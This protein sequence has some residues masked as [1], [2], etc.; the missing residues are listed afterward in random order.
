MSGSSSGGREGTVARKDKEI[1]YDKSVFGAPVQICEQCMNRERKRASRKKNKKPEEEE[2]WAQDERKR[3]IVFNTNQVRQFEQYPGAQRAIAAE[4]QMRICCYCRHH[5]EKD[6]FQVIFT[7]KD[8]NGNVVAQTIS[9]TIVITDDHK[10]TAATNATGL[11]DGSIAMP[12]D[13]MSPVQAPPRQMAGYPQQA[14]MVSQTQQGQERLRGYTPQPP[15]GINFP[16]H[17]DQSPS[18]QTPMRGSLSPGGHQPKRRKGSKVPTNLTM[19]PSEPTQF[20]RPQFDGGNMAF[21]RNHAE[22]PRQQWLNTGPVSPIA[23]PD[24]AFFVNTTNWMSPVETNGNGFGRALGSPEFN[25]IPT[26]PTMFS[27]HQLPN[28]MMS[29]QFPH[30][31]LALEQQIRQGQAHVDEMQISGPFISRVVPGEG[32]CRGGIEI[33]ILGRAFAQGLTV[34][35][36]DLPANDTTCYSDSTL[37]CRLPPNPNAGPV[38]VTLKN[39]ERPHQAIGVPV[40]TYVDDIEKELMA[41]ALTVV[42]MKMKGEMGTSKQ[43]ALAILRDNGVG[44]DEIESTRNGGGNQRAMDLEALLLTCLDVIDM[45][46]SPH[47]ATLGQRNKSGQTMLHLACMLGMQK[48]VAALLARGVYVDSTDKNGYTPLHFAALHKRS[49]VVRRL[50][51]NR[52]DAGLRTRGGETAADLGESDQIVRATRSVHQIHSRHH[53]RSSSVSSETRFSRSRSGS[54]S[55]I[56]APMSMAR[57]RSVD[58]YF[59]DS[60]DDD[61]EDDD[62]LYDLDYDSSED[63]EPGWADRR[64]SI[65]DIPVPMKSALM[66]HTAQEKVVEMMPPMDASFGKNA[67]APLMIAWM[68]AWR[69]Q[70]TQSFQ[71]LQLNI[72]V[73]PTAQIDYQTMLRDQMAKLQYPQMPRWGFAQDP[74]RKAV[75]YKWSELLHPPAAPE[76]SGEMA[77]PAYD[78]LYPDGNGS[79]GAPPEKIEPVQD[80]PVQ[81]EAESSKPTRTASPELAMDLREIHRQ[82]T[83]RDQ[84]LT[85]AQQAHL[86]KMKRIESDRRLYFFWIPVLVFIIMAMAYSHGPQ[87][88]TICKTVATFVHQ[89]V[90]E[91]QVVRERLGLTV[92]RA[93]G[94]PG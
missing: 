14:F 52:A 59:A 12:A 39:I 2:K 67:S 63:G 30:G 29:P 49:D 35:F 33:T 15:N 8:H 37:L 72:P 21:T 53:S 66:E 64:L 78:E 42:G 81:V 38:V 93:V 51:M 43:V 86:R 89:A 45:D 74:E 16:M 62:D 26:T 17:M 28:Q 76:S 70:L 71:N 3:I 22:V 77:P 11:P 34:M 1:D 5:G 36:G 57:L 83:R 88:W 69:E 13:Q 82:I 7:L 65:Q 4:T 94:V 90:N 41:L 80:T 85:S 6:G 56:M 23:Q 25:S 75:D 48:F 84:P 18:P 47:P 44:E 73:L 40:F 54:V 61:E 50:L 58:D 31:M 27:R 20:H 46:E 60:D 24:E 32:T 87:A 92:G 19:T 91:P 55:S 68:D 79:G 9:S 10:N